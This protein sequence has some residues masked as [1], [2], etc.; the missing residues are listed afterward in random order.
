[1]SLFTLNESDLKEFYYNSVSNSLE[2][3]LK[4]IKERFNTNINAIDLHEILLLTSKVTNISIDR[5]KSSDRHQNVLMARQIFQYIARRNII[6]PL[7]DIGMVICRDHS[8]VLH[9]VRKVEEAIDMCYFEICNPVKIIQKI[10]DDKKEEENKEEIS[11]N[12]IHCVN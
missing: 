2:D 12:E 1:M 7:K 11:I 3:A 8:T 6:C 5:L 10:L 9:S 4:V